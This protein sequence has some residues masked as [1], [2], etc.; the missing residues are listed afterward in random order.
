MIEYAKEILENKQFNI[1]CKEKFS[2][3]SFLFES[4]DTIFLENFV[5]SFAKF[6]MCSG[7]NKPCNSCINCKK[8]NLLSH[9]DI[10]IYPESRNNILVEDV[11]DLI[12]SS[13]LKPVEGDKKIFIFKNFSSANVQSQNKLL[14]I[15]EEPPKNVYILLCV[16]NISKIL[17]TILSRC[18]KI[19]LKALTDE[20]LKKYLNF[21]SF[22]SEDI[23]KIICSSN[24]NLT[25][26][27]NYLK[28]PIF[29]KVYDNCFY[30][31]KMMKSSTELLK[32]SCLL[33]KDK[34]DFELALKILENIYR[35]LLLVR[36]DKEILI[37]NTFKLEELKNIALDYDCDAIDKIIKKIYQIKKQMEFN[38]NYILLC[39][40][41][42]LYILE[43]K[44]LCKK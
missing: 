9:P 28:N 17:R 38:C 12:T 36:L 37:S 6:L 4:V 3:A 34:E 16:S 21:N 35:D 39:D 31:L 29:L 40:N 27:A 19:K 11:K 7:E 10:K 13:I 18:Q 1:L 22:N 14:K 25:T 24:G 42:L 30:M 23:K 33:T 32:F 20:E 8:S 43:V 5:F 2:G 26:A 44:F 41:L 15:L